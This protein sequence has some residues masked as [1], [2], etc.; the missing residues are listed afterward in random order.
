MRKDK[1]ILTQSKY[2]NILDEIANENIPSDEIVYVALKGVWKEYLF[3][4]NQ[5][6][7]I[8]KNGFMTGH[9]FGSG[10]F[11]MP[12]SKITNA[13]VNTGFGGGYFEISAAGL[14]NK[15]LNYWSTDVKENPAKQPNC[16]TINSV[17]KNDFVKASVIILEKINNYSNNS[18]VEVQSIST[19]EKLKELKEMFDEALITQEE[20]DQK[21]KQIL[22]L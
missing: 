9:L 13:E 3:C 12:Y 1:I 20:F 2:E 7:Y 6:V 21:K 5:N 10:L 8:I 11:K 4:T 17:N 19:K 22:G 14:E 16:I 15:R 18:K